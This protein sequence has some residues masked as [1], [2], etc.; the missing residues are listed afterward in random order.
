MLCLPYPHRNTILPACKAPTLVGFAIRLVVNTEWR[1]SSCCLGIFHLLIWQ[2]LIFVEL[3]SALD[4]SFSE[5]LRSRL[6]IF[7]ARTVSESIW[8]CLWNMLPAWW[9]LRLPWWPPA[10]CSN[11]SM[12]CAFLYLRSVFCTRI[13]VDLRTEQVYWDAIVLV[14][15][16][17]YINFHHFCV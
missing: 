17:V 10:E 14:S 16:E 9:A 12:S 15:Q 6:K 8:V 7:L 13:I 2:C 11:V 1:M 3:R 4:N 5:T